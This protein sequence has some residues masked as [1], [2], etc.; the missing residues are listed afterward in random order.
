MKGRLLVN[1][2][3]I[4]IAIIWGAGLVTL[5]LGVEYVGPAAFNALRFALAAATLLPVLLLNDEINRKV[6]LDRSTL[7]ISFVL[8]GL[9]FGA[10]SFQVVSMRYTSVANVAFITGMYVSIVPAIGFFIGYKYRPIIWVGAAIAFAGLYLMS[11]FDST[12]TRR[13]DLL[14]LMCAFFWAVHLLVL[15]KWAAGLN[16][17]VLVFYHFLFCALISLVVALLAE[18]QLLP[19]VAAG[20]IWPVVN[21]VVVL[22]LA[23]T[24]QVLMMEYAEVFS[25]SLILS[26]F[27]V[28]AAIAGYLVFGEQLAL[29]AVVGAVLI[30]SGNLLAQRPNARTWQ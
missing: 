15:A 28:F 25:A 16:R 5:R 9:L 23:Y 21:G 13:G 12:L 8:G 19:T 4:L 10:A 20:Y 6:L 30:L 27:A 26:L 1:M 29:V 3:L 18:D 7:L 17:L 2:G 24:I 14:A 11:S 22:G